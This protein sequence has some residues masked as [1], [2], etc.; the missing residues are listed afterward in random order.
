[1]NTGFD[2]HCGGP[3]SRAHPLG[4]GEYGAGVRDVSLLWRELFYII[5]RRE[6]KGGEAALRNDGGEGAEL[7]SPVPRSDIRSVRRVT[8]KCMELQPVE[9]IVEVIG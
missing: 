6:R 9:R 7:S 1:M 2:A 4:M 5:I 8:L 3:F